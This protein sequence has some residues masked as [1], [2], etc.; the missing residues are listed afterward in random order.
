[1]NNTIRKSF[2]QVPNELIN[3]EEI[4]PVA[5]FLFV[6]LCSKPDNWKY[7]NDT[8]KKAMAIKSDKTLQKYFKELTSKGWI[9]KEQKRGRQGEFLHNDIVLNAYPIGKILPTEPIGNFS[10]TEK[11]R[12]GKNDLHN[13][14]DLFSNTDLNNNTETFKNKKSYFSDLKTEE[15]PKEKSSAKKEKVEDLLSEVIDYLNERRKTVLP[16]SKGFEKNAS[17]FKDLKTR[18]KEG[19]TL[20][21]FKKVI[22][23]SV[24]KWG[25]NTDMSIYIRPSTLFGTKFSQY[26]TESDHIL[27]KP[28]DGGNNFEIVD[29]SN[30]PDFI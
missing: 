23:S 22:D 20:D 6:W 26:L 14:T 1:M 27:N 15:N 16:N 11:N 25:K 7:F 9:S 28:N 3:D 24:L 19:G 12:N 13:N 2:T 18:I 17:N 30:G 21:Q 5:R 4:D 29:M 10:V 8:I